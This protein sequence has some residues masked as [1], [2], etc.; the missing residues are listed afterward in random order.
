MAQ[1]LQ[2]VQIKM[3]IHMKRLLKKTSFFI[4]TSGFLCLHLIACNENKSSN[5]HYQKTASQMPED[6]KKN[7]HYATSAEVVHDLEK[8]LKKVEE[9]VSEFE[10]AAIEKSELFVSHNAPCRSAEE[11]LVGFD[12]TKR[13][14]LR[15]SQSRW[16]VIP[17]FERTSTKE[18]SHQLELSWKPEL[19]YG[20]IKKMMRE[21]ELASNQG[22]LSP[23]HTHKSYR[24]LSFQCKKSATGLSFHCSKSFSGEEKPTTGLAH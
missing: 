18:D 23:S 15:C 8:K 22:A 11:G 12:D 7:H 4:L 20:K 10:R 16:T 3:E 13:L 21:T 6:S 19:S 24:P 9:K 1:F 14:L 2:V 17:E 5:P